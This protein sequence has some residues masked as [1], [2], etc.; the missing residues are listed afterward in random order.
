MPPNGA[1]LKPFL[2]PRTVG[3]D[4]H[5][6]IQDFVR[7]HFQALGWHF[8][9]DRFQRDT[10]IGKKVFTNLIATANPFAKQRII[11]C[12]HYDSKIDF[13]DGSQ[14]VTNFVGA[15]DSAWPCALLLELAASLPRGSDDLT[16]QMVFFD[17]EESFL[18]WSRSD[19]LYGANHLAHVWSGSAQSHQ[20]LD[21]IKYMMLLDLLGAPSPKFYSF[22]QDTAPVF[23]KLA[24]AESD[25]R[26]KGLLRTPRRLFI[27]EQSIMGRQ[28]GHYYVED[29][30]VPFSMRNVP[31]VHIIPTPFPSVWH[32]KHD[33]VTALDPD[34]CHD[35]ALIIHT[36]IHRELAA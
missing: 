23:Q 32:K 14:K 27:T 11:L 13:M 36:V 17:G 1:L 34:T 21:K 22:F 26:R 30:H 20:R 3:S 4:S 2:V 16:I 18:D 33:D 28:H 8:E 24:L 31:I 10:V 5:Q 25:A 29:D 12:A 9:T 35:L 6:N 15:T 7:Q 19:S